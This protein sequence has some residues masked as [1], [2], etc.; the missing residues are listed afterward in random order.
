[1]TFAP[2]PM[3][4]SRSILAPCT[5]PARRPIVTH[6]AMTVP[7][8][9]STSPSTTTWPG[10]A[11]GHLG[12]GHGQ[13][14]EQ[15]REHGHAAGLQA[16]LGPVGD[17]GQEGVAGPGQA[18]DLDQSIPARAELG[19]LAAVERV[20]PRVGEHRLAEAR[21]ARAERAPEVLGGQVGHGDGGP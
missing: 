1:M 8:P 4:T 11:D 15:A 2:V 7:A 20:Q 14:V 10:I 12:G 16:G 18:E 6:G 9:I 17:L 19:A 5:T 13:A 3:D 21:V